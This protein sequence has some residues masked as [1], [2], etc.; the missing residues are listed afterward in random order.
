MRRTILAFG[1]TLLALICAGL[2]FFKTPSTHAKE[3]W[4]TNLDLRGTYATQ[5]TETLL[6]PAVQT[7][8]RQHLSR[9][10]LWSS[11]SAHHWRTQHFLRQGPSRFPPGPARGSQVAGKRVEFL[12]EVKN[13][14]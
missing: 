10:F 7:N 1:F 8:R 2:L 13:S 9:R 6:F 5:M 11:P 4:F 3:R 12:Q 14:M